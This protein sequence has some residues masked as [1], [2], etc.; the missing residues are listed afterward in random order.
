MGGGS[1][2]YVGVFFHVYEYIY[3]LLTFFYVHMTREREE[4]S[5]M[6]GD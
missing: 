5:K 1:V 6:G 3:V 2:K 4:D